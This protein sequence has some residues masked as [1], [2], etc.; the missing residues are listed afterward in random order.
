MQTIRALSYFR[1][2]HIL[3]HLWGSLWENP[4]PFKQIPVSVTTQ[5]RP[6]ELT[7]LRSPPYC[8]NVYAKEEHP[9]YTSRNGEKTYGSEVS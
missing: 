3:G 5:I 9:V 7:R 4:L 1:V 2:W 8:G 6:S